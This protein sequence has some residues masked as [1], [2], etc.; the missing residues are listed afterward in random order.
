[1]LDRGEKALL[2]AVF[3]QAI[4]DYFSKRDSIRQ[5]AEKWF[6]DDNY[7]CPIPFDLVCEGLDYDADYIREKLKSSRAQKIK[8]KASRVLMAKWL[9]GAKEGSGINTINKKNRGSA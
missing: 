3:I 7:K 5:E 1:M 9:F 2:M 8:T 4:R 6:F